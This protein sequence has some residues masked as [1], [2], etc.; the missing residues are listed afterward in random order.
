MT[1]NY[2]KMNLGQWILRVIHGAFIGVGSILPGVSGSVFSVLFGIYRPMMALLAHPFSTF[3]T[4]YKLFIPVG[5]GFLLGFFGLAK[6]LDALFQANATLATCAFVGLIVGLI[7]SV[8]KDAGKEG[9][10]KSS[11]VAFAISLVVIFVFF[12]YLDHG[13][14]QAIAPNP[15]WYFFSGAVWGLTFI[16]PGLSSSSVLLFLGLYEPMTAGIGNLDMGVVLPL[17]AGIM[18]VAF[19]FARPAN[20]LLHKHYALLFHTILGFVIASTAMLVFTLFPFAGTSEAIF[21]VLL[22]LGGI[23]VALALDHFNNKV[24]ARQVL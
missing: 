4:Y 6:L 11:W 21:G 22:L 7:P 8:F 23:V 3:K 19:V 5:I 24:M 10:P 14:V 15:W 13:T 18:I 9:R 17:F 20:W 16:L 1:E 2:E 12:W